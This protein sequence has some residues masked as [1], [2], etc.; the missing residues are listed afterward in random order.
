MKQFA[1]MNFYGKRY[2]VREGELDNTTGGLD[3]NY[4]KALD[5]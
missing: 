4:S 1:D 3:S 2:F 5:Y